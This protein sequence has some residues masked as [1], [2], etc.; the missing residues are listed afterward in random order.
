MGVRLPPF[1]PIWP[2]GVPS[3]PG[4]P[5]L[6]LLLIL[7]AAPLHSCRSNVEQRAYDLVV[8]AIDR[9]EAIIRILEENPGAE[10]AVVRRFGEIRQADPEAI[11]TYRKEQKELWSQLDERD[12]AH[13]R[14]RVETASPALKKALDAFTKE[15]QGRLTHE[16]ATIN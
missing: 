12:R 1:A 3:R 2:R 11:L 9:S 16:I 8:K 6:L 15:A 13:F 7:L 5:P 10:E 14:E 4:F